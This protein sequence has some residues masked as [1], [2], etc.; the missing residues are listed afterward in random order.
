MFEEFSRSYVFWRVSWTVDEFF[1]ETLSET[2]GRNTD[3]VTY[4]LRQYSSGPC[5][6][7]FYRRSR[8]TVLFETLVTQR[9]SSWLTRC[10]RRVITVS[11]M[12]NTSFFTVLSKLSSKFIRLYYNILTR[13]TYSRL[14]ERF[15][16]LTF[17]DSTVAFHFSSR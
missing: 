16:Q 13:H 9:T 6:S 17:I 15:E 8:Q 3:N 10:N 2:R 14:N 1:S 5:E 7:F 4:G 11:P 12:I